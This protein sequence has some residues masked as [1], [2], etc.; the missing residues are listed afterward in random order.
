M[1]DRLTK[2]IAY[3]DFRA[4]ILYEQEQAGKKP[5]INSILARQRAEDLD[6]RLK[7]RMAEL[8]REEQIAP[9]PPVAIGGALIVPAGLLATLRGEPPNDHRAVE[10]ARVE[11]LAMEAVMKRERQLGFDPRD[12]SADNV[13]WDVESHGSADGHLRLIEVKGRVK[14]ATTVT[15]THNE[16]VQ[17][18]NKPD[19]FILAV[20][21]VD[22]VRPATLYPSAVPARA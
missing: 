19:D 15:V 10:T 9:L 21:E 2:E 17:A 22:E 18:L 7:E 16:I 13:G 11:R 14:G 6:R 1:R 4:T 20:V 3:W 12:V 5:R 8:D